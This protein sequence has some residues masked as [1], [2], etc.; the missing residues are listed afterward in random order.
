VRAASVGSGALIGCL[1]P[2][3]PHA[4]RRG[5]YP[6]SYL[7]GAAGRGSDAGAYAA[8][9]RN[10]ACRTMADAASDTHPGSATYAHPHAF[11]AAH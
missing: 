4:A 9:W 2:T 5:R 11:R 8:G 3:S 7:S 1:R 10:G 6:L